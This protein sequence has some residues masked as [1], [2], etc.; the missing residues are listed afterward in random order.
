MTEAAPV[1]RARAGFVIS[2]AGGI[3]DAFVA[4]FLIPAYMSVVG[5]NST[6]VPGVTTLD[7]EITAIIGF[8]LA[9]IVIVGAFLIRR[10]GRETLGSIFV[11]VFSILGLLYTFGG[12]LLGLVLG[13]IGGILGVLKK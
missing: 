11:I 10:P 13:V 4:L 7:V 2:L 5:T 12:L 8:L 6:S 1:K 3:V 9:I